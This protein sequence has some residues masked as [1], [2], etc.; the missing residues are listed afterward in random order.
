MLAWS[1]ERVLEAVRCEIG[2]IHLLDEQMTALHLAVHQGAP[3]DLVSQALS[4]Q[5]DRGILGWIV[6]HGE[7]LVVPDLE[8][9][10]RTEIETLDVTL[11][12]AGVPLRA[13]G[14]ILGVL[15]V[16]REANVPLFDESEVA[17]LT[18]L[19][20][21]VGAVVESAQLRQRAEQA[22]VLEERHRLARDLHDSVTQSL[23][24]LTLLAETGRRAAL[25]GDLDGVANYVARLGQV[26]QQALK[27][28]R[29]LIYEL[30]PPVLEQEGLAGALQQRL[31]AVEGRAGIEARLLVEGEIDLDASIEDALYRIAVE[32]LNNALKHAVATMV[33]VHIH[34]QDGTTELE[35]ADNGLGF[36]PGAIGNTG[37][38]GLTTM[39]E[40][41]ERL[42]GTIDVV[43]A[44]GKGTRIKARVPHRAKIG[45]A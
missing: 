37:G 23:Y 15:S 34:V 36:D 30:R 27:E 41:A 13:G 9:D 18:S 10:P 16:I 28:M 2:G 19:A 11:A 33:T 38:M 3:L 29:L 31:D 4:R 45:G 44:P 35:M 39:R 5:V 20:E 26:S 17:L 32:A 22:A 14:H 7:P 12:Y 21:H 6:Q 42:G 24:S 43:S 8:A 1:L 25:S 40:R